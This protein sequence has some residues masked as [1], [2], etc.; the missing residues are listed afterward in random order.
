MNPI[1]KSIAW[2][3]NF[4]DGI[5]GN[6]ENEI[7]VER[8]RIR[9]ITRSEPS[10]F[11]IIVEKPSLDWKYFYIRIFPILVLTLPIAIIMFIYEMV[12]SCIYSVKEFFTN[13]KFA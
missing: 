2:C 13:K 5:S 3:L 4:P 12:E 1:I 7:E 11:D 6:R 10:Y 8:Q 9:E